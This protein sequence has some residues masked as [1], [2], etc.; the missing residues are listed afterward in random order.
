MDIQWTSQRSKQKEEDDAE[1]KYPKCIKIHIEHLKHYTEWNSKQ[2][3]NMQSRKW[4]V[5]KNTESQKV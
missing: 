2:I 5:E 4:H 3:F 1:E